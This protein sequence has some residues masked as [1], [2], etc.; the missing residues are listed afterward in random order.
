MSLKTLVIIP[1]YN[2]VQNIVILI[3]SILSKQTPEIRFDVLVVDDASP[4]GTADLVRNHKNFNQNVCLIKRGKKDGRGGAVLSGF[5]YAME[6][7]GYDYVVEMD[8]DFSH[9]PRDLVRLVDETRDFDMT[10][11]SRYIRG[12]SIVGWSLRRR[13]F[14]GLANAYARFILRIPLF[15]YTNGYRCYSLKTLHR[16]DFSR[17][18]SKGY[19]VLSE[20]AYQLYLKGARFSEIPI[21][22]VNRRAGGSN[23]T[24]HEIRE[25]LFAVPTLYWHY[26]EER[27]MFRRQ[28]QT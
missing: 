8:G 28:C 17:I 5:R 19:I 15:D 1:T 21:T 7:G 23:L 27:R 18:M 11:G 20:L 6:K 2:E 26:A 13:I 12:G 9:D 3:D 16:I 22:W 25:S 10:V 14:S 24:L 4:D